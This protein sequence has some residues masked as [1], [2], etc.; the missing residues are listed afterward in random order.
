MTRTISRFILGSAPADY[1]VVATTEDNITSKVKNPLGISVPVGY[2]DVD[3]GPKFRIEFPT[4]NKAT[5][6]LMG[7]YMLLL[8]PAPELEALLLTLSARPL[9]SQTT[10]SDPPPRPAG[11]GKIQFRLENLTAAPIPILAGTPVAV[12]F[13]VGRLPIEVKTD[14][15]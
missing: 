15:A 4:P 1:D 10:P 14:P 3:L 11:V 6:D 9:L 8:Y 5:P 13:L 2:L 12:G 7:T